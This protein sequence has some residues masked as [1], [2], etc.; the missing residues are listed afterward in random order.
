[1]SNSSAQK[2][3]RISDRAVRVAVFAPVRGVFDYLIPADFPASQAPAGCRV[4]V[5]FGT[6][7]RVGIILGE[8][9]PQ[10]DRPLKSLL[11]LLDPTPLVE[12]AVLDLARWSA[13]YYQHPLG[14]VLSVCWPV[15]LRQPRALP[16][17]G[18]R[19]WQM[20]ARGHTERDQLSVTAT[21]QQSLLEE[22]ESG[23]RSDSELSSLGLVWRDAARRLAE[24]GWISSYLSDESA[25]T[26]TGNG[27]PGVELSVA[28]HQAVQQILKTPGKF[29]VTALDGVTGS[30]KT[31]VYL[32]AIAQMCE[33]G[34]Q[35]LVLVP[36][37]ALTEQLVG[38]FRQRFGK[39]VAVMHSALSERERFLA[40]NRCRLGQARI[41]IGTRSAVWV[42]MQQLG[43][44]IIDEEHDPSYKQ[45]DGF[46]YSA[47]D[48]AVMR[49]KRGHIPIVLGSATL[50]LETLANVQ[51]GRYQLIP[52]LHRARAQPVPQPRCIDIRGQSLRA[53]LG[54]TALAAVDAHL[55]R[56][57]Q[58]LLF[59]NRRGYSPV[60]FCRACG[61]LW[62]CDRCDA[63]LVLHKQERAARC[64]HCDRRLPMQRGPRCCEQPELALLGQGTE[65]LEEEVAELF[66]RHRICRL[67]RDTAHNS[68]TVSATLEIIDTG[69]VDIIVGTQMIAKGLDFSRVTLVVIVDADSR[70]YSL[71]FRAEERLAQLI[72]QV[73]GRS[74]RGEAPGEV[75]IQ[76]LQPDHP[77]LRRIVEGGYHAFAEAALLE[78]REA[79]LPPFQAMAILRADARDAALPLQYLRAVRE[80]LAAQGHAGMTC[81]YPI[82]ALMEKRAGRHRALLALS[83]G[84]RATL[85]NILRQ[86]LSFLDGEARKHKVR[87]ALDIDPQEA[88]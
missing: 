10:G 57:Q 9:Q 63:G 75:L 29:S 56:S 80:H 34:A 78:R 4:L 70:L 53:G 67:D 84:S 39:Q 19:F 60:L 58:V 64:H 50:S 43:L 28:Q 55:S 3:G 69:G 62:R 37:I 20:T 2:P 81:G 26:A 45:Q 8:A 24:K 36:E 15:M 41:M 66:P 17:V 6:Q 68:S 13:D 44:I 87:M 11:K 73:A 48:V 18:Q 31:E 14:D 61:S 22:L 32:S 21:R 54:P 27:V 42:S 59:L 71:D 7:N 38:R 16:D 40:W 77:A 85:T 83:A 5:P 65:R 35:S 23:P 46:R 72:V 25:V 47:R 82:P 1:M 30:G 52:L 79:S 12:E 88:L 51:R 33:K 86:Q 49:A 74:G 76:T